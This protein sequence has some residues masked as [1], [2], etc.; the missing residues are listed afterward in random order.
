MEICRSAQRTRKRISDCLQSKSGWALD[1]FKGQGEKP[2]VLLDKKKN[3]IW[4]AI[5]KWVEICRSFQRTRKRRF[6]IKKW[7]DARLFQRTR[8]ETVSTVQSQMGGW[9]EDMN[10]FIYMCRHFRVIDFGIM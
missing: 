4:F 10:K 8:K 5:K 2:K 9:V 7:A 3:L 1:C 6:A